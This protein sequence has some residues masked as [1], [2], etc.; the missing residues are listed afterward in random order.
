M[1]KMTLAISLVIGIALLASMRWSTTATDAP[2]DLMP[3]AD[4]TLALALSIGDMTDQADVIA[5]GN[6]VDTRSMWVDNSLVTL[7]TVAVG[8]ALKGAPGETLTV[9]V[10]GG[11]D[12]NRKVPVAMTYPGAPRLTP[13]ENVFLFLNAD[14]EVG[15][16]NVSGFSQ[17]KFSIVEGED[18]QPMVTRD[19]T[20]VS[21]KDNDGVRRG[22]ANMTP[23]AS[24][25]AQVKNRLPQ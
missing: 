23:L 9:V 2:T 3:A 17:G 11:V 24:M 21:L 1:K 25:K 22:T 19:L 15:G 6:C 5:I 20:K 18:G 12:A 7:V 13:G 4:T 10:P 8:E 16:Y 14:T